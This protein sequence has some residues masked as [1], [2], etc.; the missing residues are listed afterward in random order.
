M[1]SLQVETSTSC[2]VTGD[3]A[4]DAVLVRAEQL[5][6]L[7]VSV[8][9]MVTLY[10]THCQTQA[11]AEKQSAVYSL[12]RKLKLCRQQLDSKEMHVNLLQKKVSALEARVTSAIEKE[13]EWQNTLDKVS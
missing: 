2:I 1:T 10:C 11:I 4:E 12:Q 3:F 8:V 5:S 7:E 9:T 13:T 6:K